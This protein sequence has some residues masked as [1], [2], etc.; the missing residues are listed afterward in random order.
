MFFVAFKD[1]CKKY[2]SKSSLHGF[3]NNSEHHKELIT[4]WFETYITYE[5]A[6]NS[7]MRKFKKTYK[8]FTKANYKSKTIPDLSFLF[9]Q[10]ELQKSTMKNGARVLNE[11]IGTTAK[12][13]IIRLK[14]PPKV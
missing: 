12:N 7:L 2:K 6:I 14:L 1:Y 11:T 5:D 4:T 9:T 3:V 10:S 8:D 13:L